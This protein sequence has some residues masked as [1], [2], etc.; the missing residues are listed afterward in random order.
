MKRKN[1]FMSIRKGETKLSSVAALMGAGSIS[2]YGEEK[3][4]DSW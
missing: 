1:L 4:L 3:D 2:L